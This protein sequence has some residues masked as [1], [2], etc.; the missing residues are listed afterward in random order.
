MSY[1]PSICSEK[2]YKVKGEQLI[3]LNDYIGELRRD[4]GYWRS[5]LRDA[6]STVSAEPMSAF[7]LVANVANVA[8]RIQDDVRDVVATALN[9][10]PFEMAMEPIGDANEGGA[11]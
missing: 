3:K 7:K 6:L 5:A 2:S 10:L 8:L 11:E 4:I 9:D 1:R